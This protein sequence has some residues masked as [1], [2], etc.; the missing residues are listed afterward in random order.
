[1][2]PRDI[3]TEAARSE[4][5]SGWLLN[6]RVISIQAVIITHVKEDGDFEKRL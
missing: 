5:V 4:N 3:W 2:H 6:V 1:M